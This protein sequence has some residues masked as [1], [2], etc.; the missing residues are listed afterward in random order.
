[1]TSNQKTR[2]YRV[3]EV[4]GAETV[5]LSELRLDDGRPTGG[6]LKEAKSER[7]WLSGADTYWLITNERVES[8][9]GKK[10]GVSKP[11]MFP[12]TDT[13]LGV[14]QMARTSAVGGVDISEF[15]GSAPETITFGHC[16]QLSVGYSLYSAADAQAVQRFLRDRS[17][18]LPSRAMI[19]AIEVRDNV[20]LRTGNRK[21]DPAVCRL[22]PGVDIRSA[23]TFSISDPSSVLK[24]PSGLALF[25]PGMQWAGPIRRDLRSD[26]EVLAAVEKWADRLQSVL[27]EAHPSVERL[28]SLINQLERHTASGDEVRDL[29]AVA[30]IL[31][32]RP[33]LRDLAP[34]IFLETQEWQA[35]VNELRETE[36]ERIRKQARDKVEAEVSRL[37]D[38]IGRRRATL[39]EIELRIE[40][41]AHRE[42]VLKAEGAAIKENVEAMIQRAA[43]ALTIDQA[44]TASLIAGDVEKL[45]KEVSEVRRKLED[46]P[47]KGDAAPQASEPMRATEVRRAIATSDQRGIQIEKLSSS[48]GVSKER[49][50]LFVAWGRSAML[51]VFVGEGSARRALEV[52]KVVGGGASHVVFC[53][54]TK[55][56]LDDVMHSGNS[57]GLSHAIERARRDPQT[58]VTVALCNITSGPCEFWLPELMENRRLGRLPSNLFCFASA[59]TDGMR[60]A[61]PRSVL[62]YIVPFRADGNTVSSSAV[63]ADVA[64]PSDL[65]VDAERQREALPL[66]TTAGIDSAKRPDLFALA[67]AVIPTGIGSPGPSMRDLVSASKEQLVWLSDL[68]D[69]R[70][71]DLVKEFQNP[72]K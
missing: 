46:V 26:E 52:A 17:L 13:A 7:I 27:G 69:G 45:R 61:V 2:L 24:F 39:A 48:L 20:W 25:Q 44:E 1:M 72:R 11:P 12:A 19:D 54:P 49:L 57:E 53:G 4:S 38:E 28:S 62:G 30:G 59:T 34:K 47:S 41:A 71:N 68:A 66:L 67:A 43:H 14:L 33:A 65:A 55:I 42:A 60:V 18:A 8:K 32:D 10:R 70:E 3:K 35:A 64:W 23:E 37:E 36:I 5:L 29:K 56:S 15:G 63:D 16:V 21:G 40:Q 51:P 22:D 9:N 6:P 58:I 50:S 31:A